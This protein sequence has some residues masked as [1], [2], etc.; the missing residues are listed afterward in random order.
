MMLL[1]VA[2]NPEDQAWEPGMSSDWEQVLDRFADDGADDEYDEPRHR[3]SR[4]TEA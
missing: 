1:D 3:P 2:E 4:Y